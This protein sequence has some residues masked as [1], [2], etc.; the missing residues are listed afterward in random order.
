MKIYDTMPNYEDWCKEAQLE[1]YSDQAEEAWCEWISSMME[2]C[3]VSLIAGDPHLYLPGTGA[4]VPWHIMGDTR[5]SIEV[6]A[7]CATHSL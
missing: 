4:V 5:D 3:P 1:P 7:Y 6:C 2:P